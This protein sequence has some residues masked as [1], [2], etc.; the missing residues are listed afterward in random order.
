MTLPPRSLY[1]RH[2]HARSRRAALKEP[3]EA[4]FLHAPSSCIA[5]LQKPPGGLEE[6]S[7]PRRAAGSKLSS[8]A[9]LRA[10]TDP[11][12][13]RRP[14]MAKLKRRL[15]RLPFTSVFLTLLVAVPFVL[16]AVD[17]PAGFDNVTNGFEN[18][19]AFR[20]GPRA[21]RGGRGDRGRPGAGLQRPGLPGVPPEPGH[22]VEQPNQRAAGGR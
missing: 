22:G 3:A 20:S 13:S 19:T 18:Q 2:R 21:I 11:S 5:E 16:L 15:S 6:I 9:G 7:L 8:E 14:Q 12:S 1:R 10:A 4:C 17:A